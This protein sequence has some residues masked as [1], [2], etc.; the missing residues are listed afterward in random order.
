MKQI[1]GVNLFSSLLSK[2]KT[3]YIY[4]ITESNNLGMCFI[5][6]ILKIKEYEKFCR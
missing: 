2:L 6:Y 5:L 4:F 1:T 3:T